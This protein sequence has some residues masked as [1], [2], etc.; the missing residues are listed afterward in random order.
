MKDIEQLLARGTATPRR[1]LRGDF[2]KNIVNYL[3]EHPRPTKMSC[4]KELLFMKYYTKPIVAVFSIVTLAAAGST[5]YAAV[6]GWPGIEAM[7]AGQKKVENARVVKVDTKNCKITSA[8]SITSKDQQ[9][10]Y[11]YQIKDS[12]KLTNAQVV[13][14]VKG[15]CEVGQSGQASLDLQ[16]ELQ[17][18]PLNKNTVVGGYIDSKVMAISATS[19]SIESDVPIGQDIKTIKQTFSR[20][21]PD[22]IVYQGASRLTLGDI[23]VGDHISV[24]YRASGDALIHSETMNP[25]DL[26]A[27]QQVVVAIAKNSADLTAAINYQKYNGQEF[28]QVVPCADGP[29]GYCTAEQYY[30]K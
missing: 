6:G 27:D 29:S 24:S 22:V 15:Y 28:E 13:Q 14:M 17:K 16:A 8:F 18:N 9:N 2:T 26:Q 23:K 12:S 1:Q 21:D 7:F 11:Y 3:D 20:I 19:I 25:S 30:K 5:A 10:T 4:I